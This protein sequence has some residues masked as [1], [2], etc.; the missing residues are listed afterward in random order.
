MKKLF[1]TNTEKKIEVATSYV[2]G[3][4]YVVSAIPVTIR[5]ERGYTSREFDLMDMGNRKLILQV[6]RSSK[7][8]E[9][10]ADEIA[11]SMAE[12]LAHEVALEKGLVLV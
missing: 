11:E 2:K 8:R 4:G 6:S 10:E 5:Q 12:K 1:D 9:Q 7:K 3:R